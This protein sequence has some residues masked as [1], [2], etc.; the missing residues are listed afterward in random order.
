MTGHAR[1]AAKRMD[2][3]S[4]EDEISNVRKFRQSTVTITWLC[5]SSEDR[6]L[7]RLRTSDLIVTRYGKPYCVLLSPP[8]FQWLWKLTEG[9]S[10]ESTSE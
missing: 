6:I 2:R 8:R 9:S 5:R 10:G 3:V 4:T 1:R 7:R